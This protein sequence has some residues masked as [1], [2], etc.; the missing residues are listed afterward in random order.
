MVL[1]EVQIFL[2][3]PWQN[4]G[5]RA[6]AG[7]TKVFAHVIAEAGSVTIHIF[8]YYGVIELKPAFPTVL[9]FN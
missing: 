6:H 5:F 3:A 4:G 1:F 7:R 2:D 8:E 9:V